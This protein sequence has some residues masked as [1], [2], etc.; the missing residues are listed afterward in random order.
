[1]YNIYQAKVK[2]SMT[3]SL[4]KQQNWELMKKQNGKI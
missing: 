2:N 4:F 1:M 3:F